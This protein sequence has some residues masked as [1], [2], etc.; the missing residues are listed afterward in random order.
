MTTVIDLGNGAPDVPMERGDVLPQGIYKCAP[1]EVKYAISSKKST[2]SISILWEVLEP[3][4]YAGTP[5]FDNLWLTKLEDVDGKSSFNVNRIKG[6]LKA[7]GKPFQGQLDV[8]AIIADIKNG[9]YC[10][11]SVE[12]DWGDDYFPD[13]NN[14]RWY[15]ALGEKE[16]GISENQPRPPTGVPFPPVTQPSIVVPQATGLPPDE[17]V[18]LDADI[19][20]EDI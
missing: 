17:D 9:G 20:V 16:V 11:L 15:R 5:I 8:D 2:P 6:I 4:D 1:K 13:K 10:I 18:E 7:I 3:S 14:V 19:N 12:I